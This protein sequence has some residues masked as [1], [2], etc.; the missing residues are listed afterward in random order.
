MS[1]TNPSSTKQ[2]SAN[3][4]GAYA[5]LV[6][7]KSLV[8]QEPTQKMFVVEYQLSVYIVWR[9]SASDR[10][11]FRGSF[12]ND[13]IVVEVRQRSKL[14]MWRVRNWPA[15][16]FWIGLGLGSKARR[17]VFLVLLGALTLV[18]WKRMPVRGPSW[19]FSEDNPLLK[20][21]RLDSWSL[22]HVIL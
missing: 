14:E 4:V 3:P 12:E 1:Q 13:F 10:N 15:S 2:G 19:V 22:H 18:K 20:R 7:Q 16:S 9:I 17:L 21:P 8:K 11:H 5:K 6:P